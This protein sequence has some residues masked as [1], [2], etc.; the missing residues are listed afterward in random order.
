MP[1]FHPEL[2]LGRFIPCLPYRDWNVR[3]LQRL[4]I[5]GSRAPQGMSIEN[6]QVPG[7][8]GAPPVRLR[9]YRPDGHGAQAA[10]FW[11]HGGGF[12]Q[13]APEQD[14]ARSIEIAR[15]LGITVVAAAYRL[16]PDHPYPAP[17]DDVHAG[18]R[19]LVRNAPAL[20]VDPDR[21]AI[22][23]ASAGGGLAAG[24]TLRVHDEGDIRPVFQLLVYPMLDDRTTLRDDVDTRYLRGWT[25]QNN[26]F[27]WSAYLGREPGGD[28]APAYAA[29]ARRAELGGLPPTWIGVGTNDLFLAEDTEYARRLESAGVP[30]EFVTVPGAF[31]GFG[32]FFGKTDVARDFLRQQIAALRP[33]LAATQ[34]PADEAS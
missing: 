6:I 13:G 19:W 3:L 11:V 21:I 17:L 28:G 16:A 22:G 31:H 25:P 5:P 20:G 24:L 14:D 15:Q 1:E 4:R 9:V 26:R 7:P 27:G 2:R 32:A 8:E 33:A 23:G 29:P 10:L 30:C 34:R 12:I 18:F